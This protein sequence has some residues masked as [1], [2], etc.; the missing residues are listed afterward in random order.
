VKGKPALEVA[1]W[2]GVALLPFLLM[3]VYLVVAGSG[4]QRSGNDDMLVLV[5]AVLAG[6]ALIWTTSAK[7]IVKGAISLVYVPSMGVAL[8]SFAAMFVC[9]RYRDCF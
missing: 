4:S 2:A 8:F 9:A 3:W 6:F 7:A 5:V 1:K